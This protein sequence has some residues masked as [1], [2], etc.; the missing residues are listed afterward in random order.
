MERALISPMLALR[1]PCKTKCSVVSAA[2]NA[3]SRASW[4]ITTLPLLEGSRLRG[5]AR[6]FLSGPVAE[7]SV[8]LTL[9]D[10]NFGDGG[11]DLV[12]GEI[13]VN[14][15][16]AGDRVRLDGRHARQV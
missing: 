4:S 11:S 8:G 14:D 12:L 15:E 9:G 5:H 7:G 13:T 2:M 10:A 16:L 1:A 3:C 6:S